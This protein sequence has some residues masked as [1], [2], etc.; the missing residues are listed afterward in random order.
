MAMKT[1][2]VIGAFSNYTVIGHVCLSVCLSV[3]PSNLYETVG[4]RKV[5]FLYVN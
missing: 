1:A 4:D 5:Y 2:I 3:C